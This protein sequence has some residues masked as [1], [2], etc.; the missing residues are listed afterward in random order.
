[1]AEQYQRVLGDAG[2]LVRYAADGIA[3]M[4]LIDESLPDVIILDIFLPGPNAFVLLHELQ[5]YAD[6]RTMPVIICSNRAADLRTAQL[7]QYGVVDVLDK[8]RMRPVDLVASVRRVL[9]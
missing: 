9:I 6:L 7:K 2:Y 8:G 1:F 3:A 4:G 5:S